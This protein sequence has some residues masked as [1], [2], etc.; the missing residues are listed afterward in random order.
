MKK[1]ILGF[2]AFILLIISII[3]GIYVYK[4]NKTKD[5][6]MLDNIQL[7]Q[8]YNKNN[9]LNEV[10]STSSSEE[11]ISP[12]CIIVEK[13]YYKDCDHIIR[14]E[15]Q[16]ED[17]LINYTKEELAQ[18]YRGW[19][20]EEFTSNNVTVYKENEGFCPEHYIIRDHNGV[21][22]IYTI[23]EDGIETLKEDTEILTMYLPQ[24]DLEKF[25]QGMEVVGSS[26]LL[27]VLED[28]E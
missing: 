25:N 17:N 14:N 15:K 16:V 4:M 1:W 26:K 23:D 24:K 7:A 6:N 28:F 22:A 9:L 20:I 18:K 3:L 19:A 8:I 21:L 5:S 13:Q 2:I 10:V 11:K 27:D 12:N